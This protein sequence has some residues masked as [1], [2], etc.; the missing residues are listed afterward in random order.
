MDDERT[1][2]TA[3][4]A[5][6]AHEG[7]VSTDDGGRPPALFDEGV[8]ALSTIADRLRAAP[9]LR[10]CTDFDGTL[11][12]IT[13]DPDAPE[14]A[15]TNRDALETLRDHDRVRVAV[16]SGRE[17]A[18]LR[19]RVGLDDIEYAGNHG[20]EIHRGGE[21]TVHPV[22]E[23]RAQALDRILTDLEARLADTD[24]LIED[25]TVSATVNYRSA[26][27]A[28]ETVR[29]AVETAVDR[30]A[31]GRFRVSPGKAIVELTPTIEWDKGKALS[32]LV[33]DHDDWLAMYVGDDTTDEAAFEVLGDTGISIHVGSGADTLATYRVEDPADVERFL[34]WLSTTGLDALETPPGP[35]ESA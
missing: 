23:K 9:G 32:L 28:P 13:A 8:D 33:A 7:S 12:A 5:N 18:D 34:G 31:P 3:P 6:D 16:I 17:L 15:V 14:I 30:V 10:F 24:C 21:T 1:D 27:V 26:D 22:A 19:P 2:G 29:D 4:D 25:K 11:T 20:L 35:T